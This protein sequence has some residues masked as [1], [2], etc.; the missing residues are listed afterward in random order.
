VPTIPVQIIP[1]HNLAWTIAAALLIE[2]GALP[3]VNGRPAE[4]QGIFENDMVQNMPPIVINPVEDIPFRPGNKRGAARI[5]ELASRKWISEYVF[6][7]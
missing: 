7:R 3:R 1:E 5:V 2:R 4:W 6:G